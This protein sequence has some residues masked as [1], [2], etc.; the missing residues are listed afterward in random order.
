MPNWGTINDN[1]CD[2]NYNRRV[3]AKLE[4]IPFGVSWET[5]CAAYI[6]DNNTV[7]PLGN[8]ADIVERYCQKDPLNTGIWGNVVK[9][10]AGC[11]PK[12]GSWRDDG[13]QQDQRRIK[14]SARLWD[15]KGDPATW[16]NKCN[17][18]IQGQNPGDPNN[19]VVERKCVMVGANEVWGEIYK[20]DPKR[21]GMYLGPVKD[22]GCTDN[23]VRQSAA[24][25]MNIQGSWEQKCAEFINDKNNLKPMYGGTFDDKVKVS[26][27]NNAGMWINV[28]FPD[29]TCSPPKWGDWKESGCV[30]E[31]NQNGRKFSSR[32]WDLKGDPAKWIDKCNAAIKDINPDPQKREVL[33]RKCVTVG[34]NEIWGEVIV[35]DICNGDPTPKFDAPNPLPSCYNQD[36]EAQDPFG[37][38]HPEVYSPI[39]AGKSVFTLEALEW[40]TGR[41]GKKTFLKGEGGGIRTDDSVAIT[42]DDLA[43][44]Y[45]FTFEADVCTQNPYL[46]YGSR[47]QLR[48]VATKKYIQCGAGTCSGVDDSGQCQ[49][50]KWQTFTIE[51][52]TGKTGP[53]CY[54]DK[55]T[56]N[57]VVGDKAAITPAGDGNV[58][59]TAEDSN[60]NAILRIMG[61]NG[62]I[63]LD[64]TAEMQAYDQSR[65]DL[66]CKKD[67]ANAKCTA[68]A[69]GGALGSIGD[70]F[71]KYKL[72]LI[73]F[74]AVIGLSS[75][76]GIMLKFL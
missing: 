23:G 72:Y 67:P 25:L 24:Q 48:N 68:A 41:D 10:D 69:L 76:L 9:R 64:P 22:D 28:Q 71:E 35:K 33:S 3:S 12:W 26:C 11:A 8:P 18:M 75:V 37:P 59:A 66:L 2:A 34:V 52:P 65:Q 39:V 70:I 31:N 30:V 4:G 40:I 36:E 60:T 6:N 13:C 29:G 32:L 21:C 16:I 55:V 7:G 27:V 74:V 63:Y 62:S 46:Q 38:K 43:S 45:H 73:V 44:K 56:L 61:K 14:Y 58:W 17:E 47:V 15:L 54:G 20:D 57:Q 50:D 42:R 19:P 49:S 5:T 1:G 51:S 53:V